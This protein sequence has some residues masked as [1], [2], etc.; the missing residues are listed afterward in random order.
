MA[1][2]SRLNRMPVCPLLGRLLVLQ[3]RV[4]QES[5]RRKI[6]FFNTY[7]GLLLPLCCLFHVSG[8]QFR[9]TGEAVHTIASACAG[10]PL[11][12]LDWKMRS[13][14]LCVERCAKRCSKK[15]GVPVLVGLS[16]GRINRWFIKRVFWSGTAEL[17]T[18]I[19][20]FFGQRPNA[21][22]ECELADLQAVFRLCRLSDPGNTHDV[23][24]SGNIHQDT[25]HQP[26]A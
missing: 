9:V 4:P 13:A 24:R 3:C 25:A 18:R 8:L 16:A 26:T 1:L 14:R 11:Y 17:R 21:K 23:C 2:V 20:C 10:F 6:M 7:S 5:Y 15:G 12:S 19:T 22:A